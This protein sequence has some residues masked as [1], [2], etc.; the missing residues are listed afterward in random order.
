MTKF[1][2]YGL[3]CSGSFLLAIFLTGVSVL[4][5]DNLHKISPLPNEW[6]TPPPFLKIKKL[7]V[8]KQIITKATGRFFCSIDK[9]CLELK[10]H[11]DFRCRETLSGLSGFFY[12]NDPSKT[13][14]FH[15]KSGELLYRNYELTLHDCQFSFFEAND[16]YPLP[17][18]TTTGA[19]KTMTLSLLKMPK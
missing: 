8:K 2:S 5:P 19:M 7:G 4:Y 15:S 13:V 3:I 6:Q 18:A 14:K 11:D 1:I 10:V 17:K 16:P 12:P 9:S